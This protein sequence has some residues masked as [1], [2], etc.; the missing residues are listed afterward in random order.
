MKV[1]LLGSGMVGRAMARDLAMEHNFSVTVVDAAEQALAPLQ[2]E[3]RIKTVKADLRDEATLGQ[4]VKDQDLVVG[5]LPGAMGFKA[6]RVCLQAGKNIVDISF[7]PEDPFLLDD[8]AKSQGVSCLVDFGVAPGCSNLFLGHLQTQLARLD[9][10]SCYVGGL[11]QQR[12]WPWEY[13]APFSPADVL[14]EYTRP[15]RYLAH[16]QLVTKP[17]L[18]DPEWIDF[19]E[20]GT[21]EAFLTDGLRTLLRVTDVPFMV[22]KT[23]RYLGYREK[24]LTLRESGFFS[25]TPRLINGVMI[26]PLEVT[27]HLLFDAWR[28]GPQDKDLTAM[29]LIATGLNSQGEAITRRWDLLDYYDPL[30]ETSSMA[31]TTGYTC[32]SAVRMMAQGLWTQKGIIPP[33]VVGREAACFQFILEELRRREIHF[34]ERSA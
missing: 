12:H 8:L 16:G 9:C 25:T 1:I 20:L 31:R 30:S 26:C 2:K 14:E 4:L 34:K 18:A 33:E 21:L 15:A 10:F 3:Q 7:F 17:A 24:I 11:P 6:L 27:A 13:K 28:L 19:D 5:A 32:T 23:C 29:R 22:E